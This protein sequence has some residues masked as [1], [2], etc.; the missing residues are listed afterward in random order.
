MSDSAVVPQVP[1]SLQ[2]RSW[3]RRFWR[4]GAPST[5]AACARRCVWCP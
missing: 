1:G 2:F 3:L 5:T 4:G